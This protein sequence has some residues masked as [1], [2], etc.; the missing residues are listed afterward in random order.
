MT[1]PKRPSAARVLAS[2]LQ[3]LAGLASP[4]DIAQ[5][6][7][8]RV[9]AG[10]RRLRVLVA[11]EAKRG[12]ST[13]VNR[14]LGVDVL[15]TGVVPVTAIA[16]TIRRDRTAGDNGAAAAD[17]VSVEYL[18]G[19]HEDVPLDGLPGLVT[20]RANPLNEKAVARVEIVLGPGPLDE[21]DVELVDTPGTG[22][23]FAHNTNTARQAYDS[24][25]AA[26]FVVTADPPISAAERDLL[27]EVSGLSV[28]TM[29]F[30]NKADQL[31]PGELTEAL[32]F[33]REVSMQATDHPVA[34]FAGSARAGREDAGFAEFADAFSR[35]L[36]ASGEHDLDRALLV[37]TRR[38]VSAL[39]DATRLAQ[40]SGEL[41]AAGS[42]DVV[43][44]FA[45]RLQ[46]LRGQQ[47]E[48]D[49]RG[50]AIERG[51]LRSLDASAAQLREQLTDHARGQLISALDGSLAGLRAEE[52]EQRGRA[53][54]TE[55]ITTGVDRWREQ[56]AGAAD[57]GLQDMWRRAVAEHERQLVGLREA[58]KDLLDLDL[59]AQAEPQRL[60]DS[61][62]FWYMFDRAPSVE[63]PFAATARRL[64]PGR[65]RRARERLL[66]ELPTLVD[67]QVGRARADLQERMQEGMRR[68]L[69]DLRR[70]QD[71]LLGRFE[72]A[73]TEAN[74]AD[75]A[76]AAMQQE[77]ETQL[78][79]RLQQLAGLVADLDG[80]LST[81]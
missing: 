4:D 28:R 33:T 68:L 66:E 15:P 76:T 36:A 45:D 50:W 55:I 35:Y 80:Q 60:A 57:A 27:A 79:R 32:E 34:V 70:T 46:D 23:V 7:A 59:A 75:E 13:L 67:R 20:E 18:D 42:R 10:T 1:T 53:V 3:A 8:L 2:T 74:H 69:A 41:I 52:M 43:T 40:R 26:I 54:V 17:R 21:F 30:L 37:H 6:D 58:A 24:L 29:L 9:R 63:L 22:S 73:L 62:G 38:L 31:S 14:L 65:V 48:R 77:H 5:L 72:R 19:R 47:C 56:E 12:K 81:G 39:L 51:L 78:T 64:A 16:T 61:R 25:D 49:D 11:G 44:A 71:D